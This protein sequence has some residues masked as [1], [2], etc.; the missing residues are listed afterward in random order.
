MNRPTSLGGSGNG[1]GSRFARGELDGYHFG[2]IEMLR[3]IGTSKVTVALAAAALIATNAAGAVADGWGHHDN[4]SHGW[5]GPFITIRPG[6]FYPPPPVY[7]AAPPPAYY[8]PPPPVYQGPPCRPYPT[9]AYIN[10]YWQQ[11]TRTACLQPDG[12]WQF[13]N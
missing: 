9:N 13:V 1:S 6:F 5:G 10:G 11:V 3:F 7:Y 4:H 8:A 12:T 2:G